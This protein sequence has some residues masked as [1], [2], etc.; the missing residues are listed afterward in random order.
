MTVTQEKNDEEVMQ[1]NY[2]NYYLCDQIFYQ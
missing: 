1:L 2:F